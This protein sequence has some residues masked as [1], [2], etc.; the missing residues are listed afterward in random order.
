MQHGIDVNS[1]DDEIGRGI[2]GLTSAYCD[3]QGMD[4]GKFKRSFRDIAR[5]SFELDGGGEWFSP[6][7]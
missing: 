2:N 7:G 1:P 5:M 6:D 3:L 4:R